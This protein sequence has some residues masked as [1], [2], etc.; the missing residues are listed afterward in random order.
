MPHVASTRDTPQRAPSPAVGVSTVPILEEAR[1]RIPRLV[2]GSKV[3]LSPIERRIVSKIDGEQNVDELAAS[4]GSTSDEV[5]AVLL[6]L[7]GRGGV[8]LDPPS[9]AARDR[10]S[11]SGVRERS[12]GEDEFTLDDGDLIEEVPA[13]AEPSHT[14]PQPPRRSHPAFGAPGTVPRPGR[15]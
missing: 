9:P 13:P 1:A 3:E 11:G 14:V 8:R 7:S 12:A 2:L 5:L 10:R 6:G 4:L 15:R